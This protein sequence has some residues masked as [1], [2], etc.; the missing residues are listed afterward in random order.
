MMSEACFLWSSFLFLL[1]FFLLLLRD[2]FI[3]FHFLRDNDLS[4]FLEFLFPLL[5][6][7]RIQLLDGL[8]LFLFSFLELSFSIFW[9]QVIA[10]SDQVFANFN[11]LVV[12]ISVNEVFFLFL[13]LFPSFFILFFSL[14]FA[15]LP[16][17]SLLLSFLKFFLLLLFSILSLF[18]ALLLFSFAFLDFLFFFGNHLDVAD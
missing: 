1:L 13:E 15:L 10:V 9:S 8:M 17:L 5:I 4:P 2:L 14:F 12:R 3:L 16:L 11:F 7:R 18:L 6:I